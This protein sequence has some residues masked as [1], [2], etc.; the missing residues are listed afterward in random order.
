MIGARGPRARRAIWRSRRSS[1]SRAIRAGAGSRRPSA[2]T[3]ISCGEMGVAAVRGPAGPDRLDARA[4]QG[5]RHAQ[6]HDRPRPARERQQHRPRPDRRARAAREFLPAV[7]RRWSSA[8]HRRGDAVA[9]TRSTACRATPTAGCSATCC[10]ANGASTARSSAITARSRSWRP[11]TTSRRTRPRRRCAALAA[12]VD[13]DLPDG[14]AYRDAAS[15][16]SRAGKVP[17]R[18]IDRAVRADADAQVPRR[19][20]REPLCATAQRRSGSP[21]MPR[22]ARWRCEAARKSLVP[23][24]ERRHA[25]ARTRRAQAD[26]AVIGPNAA[27]ARLGGYSGVPRADGLAARGH[28][29]QAR[30]QAPRSSTRRACSSPQSDDRSAD[31]VMLADPA[32]NRR[33]D[34]RGGRGRARRRHDRA[35]DRRHRTDQPRRLRQEPSRR[36]HRAS[37]SSASRTSCST[38]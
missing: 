15:T 2:R 4:R 6:A 1:T 32:E 34:R 13:S 21:A 12:G 7:P 37:T 5:L 27:V 36:P 10:A 30:R 17:S 26:V 23:A 19:A 38:R 20:V 29:R 24:H 3:R 11:S 9:T 25:A 31:E 28:A 22:R 16:R 14:T 8:P 35:R 33:A 18:A